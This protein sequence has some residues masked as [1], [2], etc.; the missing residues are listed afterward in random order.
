M[1]FTLKT[2]RQLLTALQNQGFVF[3]TFEE[4]LKRPAQ[5]PTPKGA[6]Q[7]IEDVSANPIQSNDICGESSPLGDRG[8]RG[9]EQKEKTIILRPACFKTSAGRHDVD[10]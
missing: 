8:V 1:D 9:G 3:Q 5:P 4:F 7:P 10:K 6:I 2:Y